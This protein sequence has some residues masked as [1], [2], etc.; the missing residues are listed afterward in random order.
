[1]ED[2]NNRKRELL[3]AK[4]RRKDEKIARKRQYQDRK[5]KAIRDARKRR[6]ARRADEDLKFQMIDDQVDEEEIVRDTIRGLT[7]LDT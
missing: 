5:F 4:R 6:E 3:S 1:M 2:H 7:K